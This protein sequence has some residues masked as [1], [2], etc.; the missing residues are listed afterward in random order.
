MGT[1]FCSNL[2]SQRAFQ[3]VL[4][5]SLLKNLKNQQIPKD[6]RLEFEYI[7]LRDFVHNQCQFLEKNLNKS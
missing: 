3:L 6:K 2:A 4:Y 7:S 5:K 1:Y